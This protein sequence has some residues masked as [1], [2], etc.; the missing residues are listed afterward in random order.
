MCLLLLCFLHMDPWCKP[1]YF[2]QCPILLHTVVWLSTDLLILCSPGS[3]TETRLE[4]RRHHSWAA[5]RDQNHE[6]TR[7][8]AYDEL[9][10]VTFWTHWTDAGQETISDICV[11]LLCAFIT[12]AFSLFPDTF[13]INFYML[14]S[15]GAQRPCVASC[16]RGVVQRKRSHEVLKITR[17]KVKCSLDDLFRSFR[18]NLTTSSS[19]V[20]TRQ[21]ADKG[22]LQRSIRKPLPHVPQPHLLLTP[23]LTLC[24]HL[25]GLH[26]LPAQLRLPAHL[27]P[28]TH[29]SAARSPV[30]AGKQLGGFFSSPT[31]PEQNRLNRVGKV[32]QELK[33]EQ[34][35]LMFYFISF[36]LAT[37][38]KT[39]CVLNYAHCTW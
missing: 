14:P 12:S 11:H 17:L 15:T 37:L 16:S 1:K 30:L 22:H 13:G 35:L 23:T 5:E 34:S 7:V 29:S 36:Y 32:A 28:P 10:T 4:D 20:F 3:H 18:T 25:H 39:G 19:S 9:V 26:Q 2:N 31:G 38:E 24:W 6:H 27:F 8:C 33:M 21:A